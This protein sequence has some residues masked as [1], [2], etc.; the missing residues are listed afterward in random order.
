MGGWLVFTPPTLSDDMYRYVWDGRVQAQ[1]I[2]PYR[3]P[4]AA[5]ELADLRDEDIWHYINRKTSVTVYPPGA[6]MIYAT[7]WRLQPDSVRW[8]QMATLA[9]ALLAGGLLMGVLADLGLSPARGMIYLWSPLLLF[10][11]AHAAHVDGLVLPLLVGAWWAR[12]RQRDA[13]SGVLLGAAAGVKLL[14]ALLFPALWRVDD[15]QGRWRFPLA[16]GLSLGSCYLSYVLQSGTQVIGFLP[17]YLR[18]QFNMAPL[19]VWLLEHLPHQSYREAQRNLQLLTLGLLGISSLLMVLHPAKD[20]KSALRR[21]IWPM[22]IMVLLNQNLFSW[23]LLWMLPLLA[24]FLQPGGFSWRGRSYPVGLRLDAWTGWW[25]FSG[26]VALSYTF[27][28]EWEVVPAA[29]RAQFWP[30]YIFLGIGALHSLVNWLRIQQGD[31]SRWVNR[32][33]KGRGV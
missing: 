21:C 12:L 8:F 32:I 5:D 24:I 22:G 17:G 27:F 23:Y 29:I 33:S 28:W 19:V 11:T 30:L 2:S 26:L 10:E 18:E 9:A 1:G 15:R 3:Y 4:P 6:E 13:L 20:G 16:F 14:P 31:G 25:L 7:L